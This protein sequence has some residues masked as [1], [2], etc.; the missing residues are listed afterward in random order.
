M[1]LTRYFLFSVSVLV[2]AGVCFLLPSVGRMAYAQQAGST[3]APKLLIDF[4]SPDASK[5]VSIRTDPAYQPIPKGSSIAVE[6][7]ALLVNFLPHQPGDADHPGLRIVPAEGKVWELSAYG[8]IEAKVTNL[9]TKQLPFVMQIEDGS[10]GLNNLESINV[11]PGETKVLK[12]VFGYQY[13]Y[14]PGAP[15]NTS[16]ISEIFL[17]NWGGPNP[18]NFRIEEVKAAG[19]PGEKPFD[20]NEIGYRP[21]GG[22]ILGK[23]VAFDVARQVETNGAEVRSDADG[24]L[25]V[26]FT[27]RDQTIKIKPAAG[28]WDM[29]EGNQLRIHVKNVGK[30]GTSPVLTVG[31]LQGKSREQV[32][33]GAEADVAVSFIG[34][35][36]AS[37]SSSK[38]NEIGIA[39]EGSK[40]ILISSI[41]LE[42]A[43]E[44]LPNWL[45]KKPPVTGDWVQSFDEE[46]DGPALDYK[47]WNIYGVNNLDGNHP[48]NRNHNSLRMAH[49]S[50][51]NV[52]LKDGKLILRVDKKT[53][54]NNDAPG[55]VVSDYASGLLTTYG[56]WTQRYGYFEAR[57]KLP[58]V[59]S[60]V[61]ASIAI[62]PDRGK[63]IT[64]QAMR[65]NPAKLP[66]DAGVGGS[67][68]RLLDNFSYA[69]PD[70]ISMALRDNLDTKTFGQTEKLGS[71]DRYVQPDKDGY[72]TLGLLWLP[73]S[74]AYYANGKEI[75]KVENKRVSDVESYLK[76]SLILGG[77]NNVLLNETK[78][79][80]D[81]A[82]DY[83]RAWQRKDL[84][85]PEDEAKPNQGDPDEA[86]N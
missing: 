69:G 53:G 13:N 70:R 58:K 54:P 66:G 32:A 36:T 2:M 57:V 63:Q 45:G 25:A 72:L 30:S 67:E 82:I 27:G 43:A 39:T 73:G 62:Y 1:R 4:N 49:W 18:H 65:S 60:G 19:A 38:I 5:Q 9:G 51:D 15:I 41:V 59:Q 17:F 21:E 3:P 26:N 86:K 48:W 22:V 77:N 42:Q 28:F 14:E 76:L 81:F 35:D 10:G 20:A 79:P 55:G 56:K 6:K 40:T 47:K 31:T 11:A 78:L 12:V 75:L 44:E 52:L 34:A 68:F 46:F 16:H 37:F 74:A 33:P 64:P 50:K 85:S 61:L 7:G 83:V 84:A 23:G 80:A 71:I 29:A 24:A 8:H